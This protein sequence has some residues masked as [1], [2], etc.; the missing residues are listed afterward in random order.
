MLHRLA[1]L[2]VACVSAAP[3]LAQV[4]VPEKGPITIDARAIE[5]VSD[6]EVVARGAAEIKRDDFTVFGE[7]LRYNRQFGVI[8]GEGGVRLQSGPDR[9]SGP[10]LQYNT[11]D[12]TGFLDEPSFLLQRELPAR[13]KAERLEFVGKDHYRLRKASFTTCQPGQE[14]WTLEARELDLDYANDEGVAR[15]ARLRFFDTTLL[16]TPYASFPLENR[17]RS[18]LLT[19]YYSQSSTRG[20]EFGLPYYWNIAPEAD[21]V[22]TPV[23]MAKRGTQ[24]KTLSRY[25]GTDYLGELKLDYLPEDKVT[26]QTRDQI[27]WQHAQ[28]LGAGLKA[29]VDY[30]RVS[31][32][33]YFV[34]L[35][36]GVRQITTGNVNQE[37]ALAYKDT[38]GDTPYTLDARVQH[39]QTLQ[40]P[41]LQVV[42]PYHRVPQIRFNT[43]VYGAGGFVDTNLPAEFVRFT[44]GC[45]IDPTTL[46]CSSKIDASRASMTPTVAAAFVSPGW[47]VTPKMGLR[48]VGY[49]YERTV[50]GQSNGDGVAIPF[51]SVDSGLIFDRDARWFDTSLTQTLEP[52]LFYVYAPFHRQDQIPTFDTALADFNY[53]QLFNE[54]RFVGGDRFGDANQLTMAVS[55]RFLQASGQDAFRVTLG[56]RFYFSDERVLLNNASTPRTNAQSNVLASIGGRVFDSFSYD[57]TTEYNRYDHTA[58]RYS[59]AMRYAPERAKVINFTYRYNR[60]LLKQIDLSTQWPV[61]P[62]WYAV[63]R[64]NYSLLDGRLV[65]GL[66]GFEYNAG[67]WSFR[68]VWQRVQA[69]TNVASSALYVQLELRGV[70]QLGTDETVQLLKRNVPGYSL[71]TPSDPMLTPPSAR[72][73]LP[74]EQVY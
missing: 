22:L 29:N 6:L 51:F 74:F 18:G 8:E 14:D 4:A 70:G 72:P 11:L 65:E 39:F 13:G 49:G 48:A 55:S 41:L 15:G 59:T 20:L 28:T 53:P 66:A 43:G 46:A 33:R 19:P 38:F 36:S 37:M 7:E 2:A 47:Y 60:A 73:K 21:M 71:T 26:G 52:R 62:G 31:D 40:D 30:N 34:D 50:P 61:A 68:T 69:A 9:F 64:Y 35:G 56:Q 27:S 67:C 12:D 1:T 54:N 44:H 16:G 24:L 63:G 10:K 42:S 25:L 57:A 45:Q 17:R 58:E 5:G 23:A 3:V 32:N